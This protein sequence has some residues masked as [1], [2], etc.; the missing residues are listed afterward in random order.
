MTRASVRSKI[1]FRCGI[2]MSFKEMIKPHM[3]ISV[4]TMARGRL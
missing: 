2:K 1:D 3:K 4:V